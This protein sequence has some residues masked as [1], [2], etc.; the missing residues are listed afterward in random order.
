MVAYSLNSFVGLFWGN[1]GIFDP[2]T[3]DQSFQTLLAWYTEGKLNP[4]ISKAYPLEQVANA[5][6]TFHQRRVT[7]KIIL[8][9]R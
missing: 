3:M 7:G 2:A 4:Y 6:N 1:Y 5:L 8:K 9:T